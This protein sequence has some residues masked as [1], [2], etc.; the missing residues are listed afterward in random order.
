MNRYT[1]TQYILFGM[2]LCCLLQCAC[3]CISLCLTGGLAKAR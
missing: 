1:P 3:N 2:F